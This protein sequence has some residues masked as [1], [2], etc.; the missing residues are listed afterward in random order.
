MQTSVD[1]CLLA[2]RSLTV[3]HRLSQFHFDE[4]LPPI[5]RP[6]RKPG[7]GKQAAVV[8]ADIRILVKIERRW[9]VT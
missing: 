7:E 8:H 3:S 9:E 5:F 1:F 4:T 6:L 2:H